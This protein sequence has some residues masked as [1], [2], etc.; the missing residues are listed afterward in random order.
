MILFLELTTES[1]CWLWK[2]KTIET[3]AIFYNKS[4]VKAV[5]PDWS[6]YLSSTDELSTA[7]S[8][9]SD[10]LRLFLQTIAGG[11]MEEQTSHIGQ[12]LI[13]C[14]R[15]WI[16]PFT[17]DWPCNSNT[18][19]LWFNIFNRLTTG[20][21]V[22]QLQQGGARIWVQISSCKVLTYQKISSINLL[23]TMF[24]TTWWH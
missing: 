13:Q 4:D 23:L 17:V 8:Y 9:L 22:L 16:C 19:S 20:A 14:V 7:L 21:P 2:I 6:L 12:A 10:T 18:P 5:A 24:T 15:G 11:N 3:A 1:H